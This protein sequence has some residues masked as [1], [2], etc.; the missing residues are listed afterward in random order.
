MRPLANGGRSGSKSSPSTSS[1]LF[2]TN[3]VV[4]RAI[5]GLPQRLGSFLLLSE[6]G[7]LLAPTGVEDSRCRG[8]RSDLAK[9]PEDIR[10]PTPA[11]SANIS[12]KA[13]RNNFSPTEECARPMQR[14][15][16][17]QCKL[18][19]KLLSMSSGKGSAPSESRW[20]SHSHLVSTG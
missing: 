15:Y 2:G 6:A 16:G 18:L 4:T 13:A 20:R 14:L 5:L 1:L 7:S 17:R 11:T 19:V 12:S 9:E 8:W 3:V 10:S